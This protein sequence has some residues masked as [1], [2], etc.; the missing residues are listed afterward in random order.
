MGSQCGGPW[1]TSILEG[2][3]SWARR[4]HRVP[5]VRHFYCLWLVPKST[6]S[7]F[8]SLRLIARRKA[9]WTDE[10]SKG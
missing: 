8:I 10:K 6:F 5:S 1:W 2:E 3:I 7:L 4:R 9:R